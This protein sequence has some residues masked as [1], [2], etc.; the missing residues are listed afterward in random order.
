MSEAGAAGVRLLARR[1]LR[2]HPQGA[3]RL[4]EQTPVAEQI[5]L[6]APE[7][8]GHAGAVLDRMAS[9]I[10][11]DVLRAAEGPVAARLTTAMDPVRAVAALGWLDDTAREG[12]LRALDEAAASDL[13][14]LAE[15]PPETA[16]RLMDVRVRGFGRETTARE[17]LAAIRRLRARPVGDVFV[18]DEADRLVGRVALHDVAVAAPGERL[19]R[20]ASPA[21]AVPSTALQAEVVERLTDRRLTSLPVI[22]FEGR[23]LGV[24][25]HDALVRAAQHDVAGD[26]QSM[27]GASRQERALSPVSFAIR[28]RL[29][30][31]EMNLVT[32]FL[33]ASVVGI[34]ESTIAQFTALAVLMPV[35]AGQSGNTGAQALAVTMRGLALREIRVAQWFRVVRKEALVAFV[36]GW[37][38]ALTT[39]AGVFLW[40]RSPGLSLVIALAMLLSMVAAGI[41]GVIIPMVLTS[42]RQDPAQSSSIF[43][44][45]IT[46][47][48]GFS[49]FLGTAT[50]LAWLL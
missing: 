27:V 6:L 29:P 14:R 48:V 17:A 16:G 30:W 49:S 35:V 7:A 36:N 4:V 1:Y 21:E 39:A 42:L 37:V 46:D 8:P 15:Y 45:M 12:I 18:I 38:I 3:A 28:R 13:R 11:A 10:V 31:L 43:L 9:T 33:A 2:Q 20:L 50:L 41:A 47:I 22:D 32:A 40:S 44:T 26:I 19:D 24:I 34:F 5:A 23:L 25:R